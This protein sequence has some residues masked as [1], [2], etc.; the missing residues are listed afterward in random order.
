MSF[1]NIWKNVN[2]SLSYKQWKKVFCLPSN[3]AVKI[4]T[5]CKYCNIEEVHCVSTSWHCTRASL[6]PSVPAVSFKHAQLKQG[7][8]ASPVLVQNCREAKSYCRFS[9]ELKTKVLKRILKP[10]QLCRCQYFW[11]KKKKNPQSLSKVFAYCCQK[12]KDLWVCTVLPF[13]REEKQAANAHQCQ[14]S[15]SWSYSS[16]QKSHSPDLPVKHIT[17]NW[18][19]QLTE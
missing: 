19:S 11:G 6:F 13:L 10:K 1:E 12:W 7:I 16:W 15:E 9:L 14:K 18:L 5:Q 3:P 2:A 8:W 4:L 17:C